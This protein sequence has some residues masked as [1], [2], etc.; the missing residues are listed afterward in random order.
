MAARNIDEVL[1]ALDGIVEE[2]RSAGSRLG[3]FAALYRGV[4]RRVKQGIVDGAFDD[5]RRM[6]RF[7]TVFANRYLDAFEAWRAGRS[8]SRCWRVAFSAEVMGDLA[9]VQH[10]LLGMNAHINLDLA[11]AVATVAPGDA[12]DGIKADFDRIND[13]LAA[14]TDGV[15]GAIGR[16]S[17]LMDV[18]DRVG[19]DADEWLGVFS[20]HEA[21]ADAW[22]AAQLLVAAP[23]AQPLLIE[24][25]DKKTSFLGSAI[26]DPGPIARRAVALVASTE[27][28][29][30]QGVIDALSSV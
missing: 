23:T 29:D 7:D 1:L 14:M 3:W 28:Q 25:L 16:F 8:V 17:P 13:L 6:D 11:I 4:T 18:L 30:I 19:G 5:G 24:L 10:L 27:T 2:A 21:R 9:I 20:I 12:L 22:R 15:Q 26:R